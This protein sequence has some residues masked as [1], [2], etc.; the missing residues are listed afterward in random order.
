LAGELDALLQGEQGVLLRAGG[1]RDDHR[2]EQPRGALD[3]VA[4]SLGDGVEGARVQHSVHRLVLLGA[5]RVA[6]GSAALCQRKS[7]TAAA[8]PASARS[9]A[10]IMAAD[11]VS[12]RFWIGLAGADQALSRSA[13]KVESLAVRP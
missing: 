3:Q 7:L 5:I 2:V 12:E 10:A 13:S 8:R 6:D 1:H 9:G 4:M 11:A